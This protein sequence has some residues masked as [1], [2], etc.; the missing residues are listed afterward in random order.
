MKLIAIIAGLLLA[1][2]ASARDITLT[3]A[4]GNEDD[5]RAML[6]DERGLPTLPSWAEVRQIMR[7]EL[8]QRIR[9]YKRR[10]A[11][12]AAADAPVTDPDVQ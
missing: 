3:V 5:V 8:R 4:A 12:K 1:F 11:I 7:D 2:S 9:E 6:R 10:V